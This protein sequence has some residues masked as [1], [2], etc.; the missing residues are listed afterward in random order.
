MNI[1]WNMIK[2]KSKMVSYTAHTHKNDNNKNW[3]TNDLVP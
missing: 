3:I 2:D 1:C